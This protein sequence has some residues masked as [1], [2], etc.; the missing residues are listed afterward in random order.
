MTWTAPRTWVAGEIV[1]AG[2]MNTHV[3]D[4]LNALNPA[5][6]STPPASP[7]DGDRWIYNGL[8]GIYWT[9]EHDST[10]ATYPWKFVGGPPYSVA[11]SGDV[12][13]SGNTW[14]GFSGISAIPRT[15]VYAVQFSDVVGQTP[16]GSLWILWESNLGNGTTQFNDPFT[17]YWRFWATANQQQIFTRSIGPSPI[18]LSAGTV[19]QIYYSVVNWDLISYTRSISITPIK[20]S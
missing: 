2:E 16:N 12:G 20:V 19:L 17:I 3:R 14:I 10:D 15:G 4:N 5:P 8:S 13:T 6:S 18:T 11:D 1:T 9:F 7:T